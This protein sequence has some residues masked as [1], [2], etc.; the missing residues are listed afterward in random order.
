MKTGIK[1]FVVLTFILM[2]S[3]NALANILPINGIDTGTVSDSYSNLFAPAGLTF[4]IWGLIYVLLAAF[5]IYQLSV[6]RGSELGGQFL[7]KIGIVFSISSLANTI[8]IF[9]WHY[10]I[11]YLSMILMAVILVCLIIIVNT[12][13]KHQLSVK[14]KF[15]VKLPF[16][17]YFGWITVATIANATVLLVSIGWNGFGV[18]AVIWTIIILAVGA[19]IGILTILRNKDYPYGLVILWAYAGILIKHLSDSG[20]SN[21]Y[22]QV[23]ITVIVCLV[24]I[25]AA[26]VFA[27][28]KNKY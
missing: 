10:D 1:I 12:I 13:R 27:A 8:W 4:S 25:A 15:L 3:V 18:P 11:I 5:T 21:K 26:D 2:V 22:P 19:A 17:I 14:D 24:L 23:V 28:V 20:F 9:T 6:K 16:S 7:N